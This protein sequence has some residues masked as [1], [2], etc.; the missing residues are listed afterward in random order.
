M[1]GVP[2]V[3]AGP[4]LIEREQESAVLDALV[5]RLRDGGG[6]VVVRGEAGIGKSV[7]L[8]RVR[9][10]AAAQGGRPLVTVGVESEA[11]FA[12]AGLHQLLRPV[13][14]GLAQLPESQ[15]QALEA[16]LGMGVDLKPDPFR[17]AVAAFQLICE[18]ADSAPLVL[19]VDDAHWLDRSTLSVIAFVGR[20]LEAEHVALVA[21]IRSGQSTPLDDARLPTLDLERLSAS[22]A[23]RL[24]DCKAPELH[25]VLRARVLAESAGNPLALVELARSIGQSGEQLSP[26]LA[27]LTARLERAFASRLRDLTEDTGAALLAA[28]LDSR[29]SLDEI[30]RSSGAGVESVQIAVDADLIEIVDNGVRFRHPLI[31][32]AVRQAASARQV[33][34]IYAALAEVVA[35]PERQ[36]WHRAM[37]AKGPD[38]NIAS[39]LEQHA[40]LAAARGAVT[41]A[42]AALER[43]AALTADSRRRGARLVAAAEIAYELGLVESAHRL[44]DEATSFNLSGGDVAR[45]AWFRQILSGSVWFESGAAGTFVTIAEQLRDGGDADMALRSLVPIAHRCWWTR[46]KTR[47]REY[48]VEASLAMGMVDDDP[49]VLAVIGLAHPEET[50]PTVLRRVSRMRLHE[51]TDPLAAMYVGI[52]AEKA[53]DFLKGVRFL[54]SAVDGLRDQVRLV[55]LTQALVHYAWAATHVGEWPAAAAAAHQAAGLARDTRQPQYGLTAELV[56]ALA[57]ALHGTE[58]DIESVLAEPE[59]ALLAMKGGPLLATAHLARGAAA[60]GDGRHEDAFQHLWPVFDETDSAFHRFMRW[61]ALLDL[62]EAAAGSGQTSRLTDVIADLEAISMHSEPPILRL[63]LACA[64]PLLATDDE[65]EPLFT[66]A[67]A[68]DL[69][70]Y[71][72]LR[73]RTLF[74]TGRWLRRQRRSAES[75]SPLRESVALFDALGASAWSRR[76]RHELR[77]AG[78]RIGRRAP[79]LRDRLTAQELQIAQLAAEGLSNRQIAERLFLSPRTIGGHLYRIFPKLEITAR[80][81]LREVFADRVGD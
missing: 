11:E 56:G 37:A 68:Q 33:L 80:A 27:T 42:G 15:R 31:R 18:V 53:G 64:R 67:L 29:A 41:V 50:G 58:S 5:D 39:A 62:V 57:T 23:A 13:I 6:A 19:I 79:D 76:A 61:P 63:S 10:R 55:P 9:R 47:T 75:R 81:Q 66:A 17:V 1:S 34:A 32:S 46:T 60:I 73:A 65:A 25:P 12:Y 74:S 43:A 16:A 44:V 24:L 71:P 77:A 48:L 7:L 3:D 40:R 45:L 70:G 72:F 28:A 52:A 2:L 36:L 51:M 8:Q 59:R 30:A 54:S 4:E 21:A 14:G 49:R 78:E 35:D 26:G 20:R 69:V 38:E 22:A